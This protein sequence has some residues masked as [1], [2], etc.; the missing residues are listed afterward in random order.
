MASVIRDVIWAEG[1]RQGCT[2][3]T[4]KKGICQRAEQ[5][6]F[7]GHLASHADMLVCSMCRRPRGEKRLS[8]AYSIYVL[9]TKGS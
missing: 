2:G 8:S 7:A 5:E 1:V 9:W 4:S 6:M 3:V